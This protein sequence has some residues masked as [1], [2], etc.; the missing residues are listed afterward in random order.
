[1]AAI[2]VRNL[3]DKVKHR[4][5]VR[6]ARHGR[7]ME[8]EARAIIVEAV[9]LDEEEPNILQGLHERFAELGGVDLDIPARSSKPRVVDFD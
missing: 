5:R 6:A 2:T 1:M 7:S 4:L 8:A 9:G 3:D